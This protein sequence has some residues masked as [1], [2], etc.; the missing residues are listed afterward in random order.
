M[1]KSGDPKTPSAR[2]VSGQSNR[3]LSRPAHALSHEQ[4]AAELE[5]DVLSGLTAE[6]AKA[7]LEKYGRNDLGEE[8]GV[9]PLKIVVA[10]IANAMTLVM[11]SINPE[12]M[13]IEE[14]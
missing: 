6:E 8:E 5:V 12:L 1:A 13:G 3:P 2:Q 9:Q 10:Q 11:P 7:R 4:V 14:L